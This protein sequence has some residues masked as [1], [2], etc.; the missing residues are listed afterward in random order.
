MEQLCRP[1]KIIVSGIAKVTRRP[2]SAIEGLAPPWRRSAG[3]RS[4]ILASS[5]LPWRFAGQLGDGRPGVAYGARR[6]G[7]GRCPCR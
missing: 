3:D 2:Q 7:R 1:I 4:F 6:C 5:R